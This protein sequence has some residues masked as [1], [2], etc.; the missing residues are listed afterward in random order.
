MRTVHIQIGMLIE[1]K[2][3]IL[4]YMA[5]CRE[6]KTCSRPRIFSQG[7]EPTG[8]LLKPKIVDRHYRPVLGRPDVWSDDRLVRSICLLFLAQTSKPQII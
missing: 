4:I 5:I 2:N 1:S 6:K 3:Q 7:L 8:G